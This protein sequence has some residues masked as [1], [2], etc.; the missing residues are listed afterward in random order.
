MRQLEA[1]LVV[2]LARQLAMRLAGAME[3]LSVVR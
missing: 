1:A 2:L 3:R